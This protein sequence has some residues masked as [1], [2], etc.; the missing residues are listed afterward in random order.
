MIPKDTKVLGSLA[1]S[2]RLCGIGDGFRL[3]CPLGSLP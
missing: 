1:D 2:M 3:P